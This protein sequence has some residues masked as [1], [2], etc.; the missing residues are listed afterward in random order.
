MESGKSF[1]T[2]TG[3]LHFFQDRLQFSSE[4]N[5]KGPDSDLWR[6]VLGK[7]YF[8]SLII[9]FILINY[10]L[11]MAYDWGE[12]ILVLP[13]TIL[14]IWFF[15]RIIWR[16]GYS[17]IG[18]MELDQIVKY[19]FFKSIPF[20]RRA[21]VVLLFRIKGSIRKRRIYMPFWGKAS[22]FQLKEIQNYI[23]SNYPGKT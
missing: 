4:M 1:K 8:Y 7:L 22:D 6:V 9:L 15:Y 11:Y 3:Y 17:P 10:G 19:K 16:W 12:D 18:V 23:E 13:L 2:L 5:P 14:S 20:F 21:L